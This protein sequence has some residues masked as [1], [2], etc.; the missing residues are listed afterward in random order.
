M[1]ASEQT[2]KQASSHFHIV[3]AS[4]GG[5]GERE[6]KKKEEEEGTCMEIIQ[7]FKNLAKKR[8]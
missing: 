2:S 4:I 5:R 6:V 1:Q 8:G 3:H 7:P